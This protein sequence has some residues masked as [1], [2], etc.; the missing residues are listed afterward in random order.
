MPTRRGSRNTIQVRDEAGVIQYNSE[1]RQDVVKS[2][3]LTQFAKLGHG[4]VLY[5]RSA[6][7]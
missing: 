5:V 2:E 4:H 6:H 7:L 3:E 1:T